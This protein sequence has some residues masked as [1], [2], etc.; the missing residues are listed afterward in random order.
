MVVV[1]KIAEAV[2]PV[3]TIIQANLSEVVVEVFHFALAHNMKNY[4]QTVEQ[5]QLSSVIV[6]EVEVEQELVGFDSVQ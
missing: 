2:V 5:H 1:E 3:V 4:C 6:V